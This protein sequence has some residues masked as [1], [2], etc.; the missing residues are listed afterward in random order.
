MTATKAT[1]AKFMPTG[2]Q[3]CFLASTL[4]LSACSSITAPLTATEEQAVANTEFAQTLS[5]LEQQA[6]QANQFE[7]RYNAEK[8]VT[9]LHNQPL[10][11]NFYKGEEQTKVFYHNGKLFALQDQTGSYEFNPQ[12][13]LIRAIDVK[14]NLVDV[15]GL[16]DKEKSALDYANQLSKRFSLNRAD[17]NVG[18]VTG[19]EAKLNYLCIDKIKQAAQTNRVFR[20]SANRAKTADRLS[21]DLRLNGN[22]YYH[23]DCQLAGDRVVKLSLTKK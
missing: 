9:Y 17:K 14:G 20:S 7:Y 11:I 1:F 22:Q 13:Q 21:A 3:T 2:V 16:S 5:Q 4:F 12:G 6:M 15:G 8:Y 18:R 19:A 23:M 10:L